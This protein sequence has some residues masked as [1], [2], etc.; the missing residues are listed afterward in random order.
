[1]RWLGSN[2]RV[3]SPITA[4][5]ERNRAP[6]VGARPALH[7]Q[8]KRYRNVRFWRSH[9][10]HQRPLRANTSHSLSEDE[11]Q[12]QRMY[13]DEGGKISYILATQIQ[14]EKVS[15]GL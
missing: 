10:E 8:S 4:D 6:I 14:T 9:N 3:S 2:A 1:M 5:S 7:L 13:V 11:P 12:H 15:S